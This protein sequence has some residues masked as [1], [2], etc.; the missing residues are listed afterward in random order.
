MTKTSPDLFRFANFA[1]Y[2]AAVRGENGMA[3]IE[4]VR[5]SQI[6]HDARTGVSAS[7]VSRIE[8]GRVSDPNFSTMVKLAR[9]YGVSLDVLAH[10]FP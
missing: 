9:G 2:L 1:D 7:V 3:M 5:A 4:V 6:A 8:A 10:F